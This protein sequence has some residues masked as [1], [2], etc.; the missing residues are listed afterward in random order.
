MLQPYEGSIIG[1]CWPIL[2]YFKFFNLGRRYEWKGL[3]LKSYILSGTSNLVDLID[4]NILEENIYVRSFLV[5]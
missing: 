4:V 5:F 2:S 3:N 1:P